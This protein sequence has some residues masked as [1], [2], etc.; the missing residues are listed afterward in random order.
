MT[1]SQNGWQTGPVRTP[2]GLDRLI[3]FAD[4]VVAIAITLLVLPLVDI[5]SQSDDVSVGRL[6]SDHA[7]QLGAFAL[8]FA[9]IARFWTAHHSTFEGVGAYDAMLVRLTLL[10]LAT[11]AF[12]PFPTELLGTQSGD[13]ANTLYI[14]TLLASSLALGMSAAWVDRHPELQTVDVQGTGAGEPHWTMPALLAIALAL[15]AFVPGV[16]MWPLLLL[17]LAAP[18]D[19]I[20]RRRAV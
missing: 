13:G 14:G 20:R 16:G 17:L 5:A 15:A 2:R 11:V 8:S 19:A 4:A 9:V 12:L 6:L 3:V 7:G 1:R 18:I 10:W